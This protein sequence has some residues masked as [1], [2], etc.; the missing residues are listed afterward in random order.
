[1]TTTHIPT[2][3]SSI[4]DYSTDVAGEVIPF[5]SQ[6]YL[7]FS[8]LHMAQ[9]TR[10]N[11]AGGLN[12]LDDYAKLY[13]DQWKSSAPKGPYPGILT[14]YTH[15]L[16]FSMAQLSSNPYRIVRV[17]K[18]V[19]LPFAVPNAKSIS[20]LSLAALQSA[21]RL[22]LTDFLE[23]KT[24]PKTPGR[25]AAAYFLPLAIKPNVD[26][27]EDLIYTPEDETNDWLLAKL[28]FNQ[29]SIMYLAAIR[30]LNEEH[31]VMAILNR[32][33]KDAWALGPIAVYRLL[34]EGGPMEQLFASNGLVHSRR[35]YSGTF[36]ANYFKTNVAR[37]GL[38]DSKFGPKP[39]IFPFYEDASVIYDA[40]R[41]FMADLVD[42]YYTSAKMLEKDVDL[43]AWTEG[44][45]ASSDHRLSLCAA[46][47]QG[48]AHRYSDPR[49]AFGIHRK[50]HPRHK[51]P[52]PSALSSILHF[53]P[54]SLYSP[55]PTTR[56]ISFIMPYMPQVPAAIGQISLVVTFNRPSFADSDENITHMFD[57]RTLLGKTNSKVGHAEKVFREKMQMFSRVVRGRTFD[58]KGLSQGMPFL[59]T[60]LDPNTASYCLTIQGRPSCTTEQCQCGRLRWW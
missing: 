2:P 8:H 43:Q 30:T 36:Q 51:S 54:F 40:T 52:P 58:G 50:W 22:F 37:H 9:L 5:D 29:N 44:G 45:R 28:M 60:T 47:E 18:D 10:L 24:Q 55:I 41:V 56:N 42:S 17:A 15:D 14:N 31:P 59:W 32:L 21:G 48:H 23:Q 20:T 35:L 25:Y 4:Q 38:I 53:S 16:T 27:A 49:G 1:M 26:G 11:Q 12:T 3:Q 34:F 57:D 19:L 39:K 6:G 33:V 7:G 46:K 13:N